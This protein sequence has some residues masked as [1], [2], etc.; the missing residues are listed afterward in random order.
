M[1]Q[2]Y[3]RVSFDDVTGDVYDDNEEREE[4]DDEPR[5]NSRDEAE[6]DEEYHAKR[7]EAEYW[8]KQQRR[9]CE[10]ADKLIRRAYGER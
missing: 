8:N 3:G 6:L 5:E 1:I 10:L 2:S 7:D 4:R 9:K